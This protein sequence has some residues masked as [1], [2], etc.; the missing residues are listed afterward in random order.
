MPDRRRFHDTGPLEMDPISDSDW[1]KLSEAQRAD[2]LLHRHHQLMDGQSRIWDRLNGQAE[3]IARAV[4][5]AHGLEARLDEQ[6]LPMLKEN[7]A[8]TKKAAEAAEGAAAATA[9]I[10]ERFDAFAERAESLLDVWA[11]TQG[12]GRVVGWV[13][14]SIRKVAWV[15]IPATVAIGAWNVL[16]AWIKAGSPGVK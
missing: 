10:A 3:T 1:S 5:T 8:A 11:N 7:T 9:K 4:E 16:M 13:G 15:V 14:D 12:F 2:L 6:V